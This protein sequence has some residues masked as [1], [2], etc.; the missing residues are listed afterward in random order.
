MSIKEY[1]LKPV[2]IRGRCYRRVGASNKTMSPAE[3]SEMRLQSMGTTWNATPAPDGNIDDIEIQKVKEYISKTKNIGRRHF[4]D[5][6]NIKRANPIS[7][8]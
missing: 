1:P 5:N 4:K 3:I 6:E 7:L 8:F 2:A